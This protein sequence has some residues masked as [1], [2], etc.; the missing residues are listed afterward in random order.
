MPLSKLFKSKGLAVTAYDGDGAVLLAFDIDEEKTKN[1]AGFAVK[2]ATPNKGPYSSNEYWLKN[3]LSFK[4]ELAR[5]TELTPE[6]WE[7]SN[8]A[9]FQ[10]FH[11]VH[12]PGAGPG[13]YVYTIYACYFNRNGF[14]DLDSSVQAE[15]DLSYR[16][17]PNLELGF[18]RGYISSQAYTDRFD[19]KAI[20]PKVKSIDFNT[21]PYQAQ[22]E[23]LGAHARKM[24][25]DFLEE[26]LNDD[27]ISVDVFSYDFDEPDII[28]KLAAMGPRVR[29]FQDNAPL[30]IKP[31]SV[32]P[33][34]VDKLK[35]AGAA[36]KTGNF[37]RF[38]H[39]KVMIQKK[40]GKPVKV[41]TGSANFSLRGFYIQANSV[42][43]FNDPITAR[44]YEQ[45]FGQAFNDENGFKSSTIA[46]KWFEA[47]TNH[48]PPVSISYAPHKTAFS[49]ETVSQA[50]DSA[51][52]SVFFAV[53]ETS[54]GGSVMSALKNLSN[55]ENILSLGTIEQ[56]SQLSLFKQ[57]KNSGVT[58]F[59]FLE[60]DV[61]APF[62]E[63]Y[64]GGTGQVIHHKFV[65]CD[66]NGDN[67]VV[68]CGSSNLSQGG[69][70]S[71]GDN[72]IEIRDV[73]IAYYYAIE[74]IRLFD[75]Y[76]FRSLH[77]NSTSS[78]PLQLDTT[79]NWVKP[80]YDSNDLKCQTRKLFIGTQQS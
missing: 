22:Y 13:K 61:P 11:W 55:R 73:D 7:D 38:A 56:K 69:E 53:M 52:S 32:E 4:R 49:L 46:S 8:K 35:Q 24:L 12:F 39:N 44:L 54:G 75:H 25:F 64:S 59:E 33:K 16:A 80:F 20:R 76:R 42:L 63:E 6:M 48:N 66:F 9:P 77:E 18:T 23:W 28:R 36:V 68:F 5:E 60:K 74:A 30:H 78:K 37:S 21:G 15:V 3:R 19:N 51:K 34:V 14:V 57:G 40:N 72:L 27:S 17:F 1:L 43:V 71:N 79:D 45:A 47:T 10:T 67:P 2:V 29:V 50:I 58:S 62:K 31:T 70:I 26:C 41:L 65:V